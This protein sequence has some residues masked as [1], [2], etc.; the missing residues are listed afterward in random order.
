MQ[1]KKSIAIQ[2]VFAIL[3]IV[4]FFM[5]WIDKSI[6]S[7]KISFTGLNVPSLN[8]TLTKMTN[9]MYT[10]SPSKKSS[11]KLGY[12]LYLVPFLSVLAVALAFVWKQKS[13]SKYILLVAAFLGFIFA[14]YVGYSIVSAL[15]FSSIGTGVY[16]L[17]LSSVAYIG[18]FFS[19]LMKRARK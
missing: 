15:G 17:F 11:V 14:I 4:A 16:L 13:L 19:P 9:V 7:L 3:F 10:F 2:I 12:V 18:L 5:P 6:L 1:T 8:E